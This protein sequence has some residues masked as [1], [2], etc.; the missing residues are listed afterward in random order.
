GSASTD[1]SVRKPAGNAPGRLPSKVTTVDD[2]TRD[3]SGSM[4]TTAA[5][6]ASPDARNT[7]DGILR[8]WQS[9]PEE[10]M[11][12]AFIGPSCAARYAG[13]YG[14]ALPPS[15]L[16]VCCPPPDAAARGG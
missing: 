15:S 11:N 13:R 6:R 14:R 7:S 1:V 4:V 5:R 3:C 8:V 12:P 2:V 9:L 10:L 16:D